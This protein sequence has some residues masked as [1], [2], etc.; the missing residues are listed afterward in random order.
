MLQ[1]VDSGDCTRAWQMTR[2]RVYSAL[3]CRG[4]PAESGPSLTP[5]AEYQGKD[6]FQVEPGLQ[7]GCLA[8]LPAQAWAGATPWGGRRPFICMCIC[9]HMN[10][11]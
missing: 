11:H 8:A 9:L 2:P 1:V 5:L 10:M 3:S 6:H 4:S 7:S